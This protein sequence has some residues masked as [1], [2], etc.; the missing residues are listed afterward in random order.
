[1]RR[2]ARVRPYRRRRPGWNGSWGGARPTGNPVLVWFHGGGFTSGSGGWDWYDGARLADVGNVV[3]VTA[4]YRVGPLGYLSLPRIGA[5]NLGAQ[6]Q[7]AVL[8]WV[9]D[10]IV[11]FGGDPRAVTVGGQSAGSY[12]ALFL[13]VDPATGGSST[14]CSCRAAPRGAE[15]GQALRALPVEHLLSAYGGAALGHRAGTGAD[16]RHGRHRVRRGRLPEGLAAV[17]AILGLTDGLPRPLPQHPRRPYALRDVGRR[18]GRQQ[19]ALTDGGT[20]RAYVQCGTNQ[21]GRIRSERQI[22]HIS[23]A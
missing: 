13:A 1:M 10:N 15:P 19:T 11:S 21:R 9:R 8:R 23:A 6:D 22:L 17:H 5:G 12:S 20:A 4:N 3:V 16:L 2:C 14:V 7:A 18:G